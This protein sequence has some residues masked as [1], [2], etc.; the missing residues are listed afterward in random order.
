MAKKAAT[1]AGNVTVSR[2]VGKLMTAPIIADMSQAQLNA[3]RREVNIAKSMSDLP[4]RIR[5]IVDTAKK[6]IADRGGN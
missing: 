3:F 1:P 5:A 6:Q 4:P 2:E